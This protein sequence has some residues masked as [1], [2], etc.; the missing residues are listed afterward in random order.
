MST[1]INHW[2]IGTWHKEMWWK[3]W[4]NTIAYYPLETDANNS[5]WTLWNGTLSWSTSFVVSNNTTVLLCSAW[6][7]LTIPNHTF[8]YS[9][10]TIV[11]RC[12]YATYSN[13]RPHYLDIQSSNKT[14]FS[15]QHYSWWTNSL[16]YSDYPSYS[17]TNNVQGFSPNQWVMN[18]LVVSNGKLYYYFNTNLVWSKTDTGISSDI[19]INKYYLWPWFEDSW[20][21]GVYLSNVI[22]ENKSRT[23]YEITEYYNRSKAKYGL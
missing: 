3:P 13:Y 15:S 21:Y 17:P 1:L 6:W 7:L 2:F 18:T 19:A 20:N 14:I 4:A 23:A 10:Y 5:Y 8:L 12:K 16:I 9:W 22:I 11:F